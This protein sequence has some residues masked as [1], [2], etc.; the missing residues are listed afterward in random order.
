V[1]L[2][3]LYTSSAAV[4]LFKARALL[5]AAAFAGAIKFLEGESYQRLIQA[6]ALGMRTYRHMAENID[7]W[8]YSLVDAGRAPMP[9]I[10]GIDPR[11]MGLSPT[12]DLAMFGAGGLMNV[13]Y[14]TNMV[15]GMVIAYAGFGPWAVNHGWVMKKGAVLN[16]AA[17]FTYRDVLTGWLLWPG[18]AMLVCASLAG[19]F[20]KPQVIVSAFAGLLGRKKQGDDPLRDIEL[21]LWV[22]WAGIPIVGAVGVWMAHDWFD[23][24]WVYGAL[25]IP[26]IIALTLIAA[27]ATA[28][29]S[30]TP[31]GS[32]SKITQFTFG[33]LNPKHAPTNLMTAC[34]TTEVASNASNLLMDIKPGYMLGAKPRQQVV[35]H[36][37]GIFA[38]AM[39]S[40]PLFYLLFLS[41]KD[42][43][44]PVERR[45]VSGEFSFTAAL[46]WKGI[47]EFIAGFTEGDLTQ[48]MHPSA[49]W[50]MSIAAGIG[51]A[52][53]LVRIF[54]KNRSPFS[55]L[56]FGLGFVLPPDSTLWM[57]L[58]SLFFWTMGRVYRGRDETLG[59]R[60]WI[61]TREPI[62][63][64][65]IAGAA[66]TG[67]GNIVL[68][69]VMGKLGW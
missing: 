51:V 46:Q 47:S 65:L 58:G 26:L 61:G 17:N 41:G 14:A 15:I 19:F 30:I 53:E 69:V 27:N 7:G 28:L 9:L 52:F 4:G 23:V 31:T 68:G 48:V 56:A 24:K 37:I 45:L 50:A 66:L 29:T 60:L 36:V 33:V 34:M 38:G 18:V 5:F 55:P 67:I 57:F 35:G 12:L 44:L 43:S 49:I 42:A 64:G 63:A 32:L 11:K 16:A 6:K 59:H 1:V 13:R 40:T 10:Q 54:S 8:Y 22:S 25:S 39:A 21:P 20:A 3:T 2:D 62:C